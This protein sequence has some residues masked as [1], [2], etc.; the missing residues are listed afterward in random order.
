MCAQSTDED[1]DPYIFVSLVL[2][3][4]FCMHK[5]TDEGWNPYSLFIHVLSTLLCVLNV[6]MRT[7]THTDL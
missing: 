1:R 2:K 3:V 4:L 6:Q 7:G 5:N